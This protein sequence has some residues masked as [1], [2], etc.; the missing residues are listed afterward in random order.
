MFIGPL[1]DEGREHIFM[2][3]S[4]IMEGRAVLC[5]RGQRAQS[6]ADAKSSL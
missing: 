2:V 4:R 3:L 5:P 6:F 1:K